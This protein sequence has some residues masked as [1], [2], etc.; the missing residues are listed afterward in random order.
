MTI[1]ETAKAVYANAKEKGFHSG[2]P[3]ISRMLLLIHA[4]VSE[5]CEADRRGDKFD[6]SLKTIMDWKDDDMFKGE[7]EDGVKG[8]FDEEMADIVIR[9]M[10]TCMAL[11]IDLEAHIAAKMRYNS[12]R[13]KL[14]GKKY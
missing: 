1:N 10:D 9:V 8:T 7:Y 2:G 4:E 12:L 14:H 5:A 13:E 6:R 11:D 3:I